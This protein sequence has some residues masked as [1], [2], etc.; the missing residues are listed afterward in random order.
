MAIVGSLYRPSHSDA[1]LTPDRNTPSIWSDTRRSL[2][3]SEGQRYVPSGRPCW[4]ARWSARP[5]TKLCP[6]IIPRDIPAPQLRTA[7]FGWIKELIGR[8]SAREKW[9]LKEMMMDFR[10]ADLRCVQWCQISLGKGAGVD[11]FRSKRSLLQIPLYPIGEIFPEGSQT[12]LVSG[13]K[14]G[15]IFSSHEFL[16]KVPKCYV[17]YN[18]LINV[19]L[20]KNYKM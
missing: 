8:V 17:V 9:R 7:V 18:F 16:L 13:T 20:H 2:A 5:A 6:M 10:R 3:T 11:H 1:P 12:F 19:L 14:S 15:R 4:P